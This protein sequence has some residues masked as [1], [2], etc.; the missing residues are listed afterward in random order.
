MRPTQ[1]PLLALAA[2]GSLL[3]LVGT[4][5]VGA[6]RTTAQQPLQNNQR[7]TNKAA[8]KAERVQR[9]QTALANDDRALDILMAEEPA[10][11][12]KNHRTSSVDTL[13]KARDA[14][15]RLLNDVEGRE[16]D[17]GVDAAHKRERQAAKKAQPAADRYA[18]LLQ[19]K[20]LLEQSYNI[21]SNDP[22]EKGNAH[23]TNAMKFTQ[24]AA[25]PLQ[26]EIAAYAAA[27]PEVQAAQNAQPAAAPVAGQSTART[28]NAA[29]AQDLEQVIPHLDHSIDMTN[30]MTADT[31]NVKQKTLDALVAARDTVRQMLGQAQGRTAA[32]LAKD[33]END[34]ARDAAKRNDNRETGYQALVRIQQYLRNDHIILAR[35][36]DDAGQLKAKSLN[37]IEQ[38]QGAIQQEIDAYL[39][40]HPEQK[41]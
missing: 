37:Y 13:K 23:H 14:T 1:H 34:R 15:Q 35:Q 36:P 29:N 28:G 7:Q 5:P 40:A 30:A 18:A 8:T 25:A 4:S 19:A 16:A 27:H 12:A 2:G 9:L 38:A 32:D 21:L 41:R 11:N 10:S 20:Q 6:Q 3:V 26:Q 17:Q 22:A 24:Q 31:A 39:K 33:V